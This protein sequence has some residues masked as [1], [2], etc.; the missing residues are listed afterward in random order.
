MGLWQPIPPLL[1]TTKRVVSLEGSDNDLHSHGYTVD[2]TDPKVPIVT[3]NNNLGKFPGLISGS[4][5]YEGPFFGEQNKLCPSATP[6][7]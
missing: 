2:F 7:H 3:L 6:G 5:F 4:I 1:V